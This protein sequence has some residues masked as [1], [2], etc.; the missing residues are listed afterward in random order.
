MEIIGDLDENGNL[1][2]PSTHNEHITM[3]NYCYR[4]AKHP[5]G[6]VDCKLMKLGILDSYECYT[7]YNVDGN[8]GNT[9]NSF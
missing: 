6:M 4:N 3:W 1:V 5:D 2:E 8:G 9:I 7:S